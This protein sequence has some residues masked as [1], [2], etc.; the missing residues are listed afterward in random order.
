MLVVDP[1]PHLDGDGHGPGVV[2][3]G[4][5]DPVE[6]PPLVGQ[7]RPAA[8]ARDLGDG[9]AEVEV[10]VVGQV[11]LDDRAHGGPDRRRV[12]TV[13]LQRARVLVRVERDHAEGQRVAL[14]EPTRGDHFADVEARA[15]LTAQAAESGVGDAGHRREH[16]GG[17]AAVRADLQR[18]RCR[19]G[20]RG[21]GGS[22]HSSVPGPP[23]V[24]GTSWGTHTEVERARW[25]DLFEG[26]RKSANAASHDISALACTRRLTSPYG[27]HVEN[28]RLVT[29][30]ELARALGL[31]ARTIQRYRQTGL[32]EPELVSAGG[33]A[34]WDVDKV[35][36]RL[37][38]LAERPE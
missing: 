3:G 4:A 22:H 2:D 1:D 30:A 15:L 19:A 37:R 20:R 26:R 27:D 7:R 34:R 18:A 28:G 35:R 14:H 25:V 13:E 24:P 21:R 38:S 32:L 16:D 12:D 29:T 36:A 5:H 8:P 10:D 17:V 31:S 23:G 33:H 9:A 11:L 6:E